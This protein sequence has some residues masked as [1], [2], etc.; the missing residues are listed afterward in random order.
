MIAVR[1]SEY[2]GESLV[3]KIAQKFGVLVAAKTL[4]PLRRRGLK[5]NI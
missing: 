5:M 3:K 1:L 4:R 2:G